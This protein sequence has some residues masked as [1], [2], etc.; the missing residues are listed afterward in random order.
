MYS[1]LYTFLEIFF[2]R[3]SCGCISRTK[4]TRLRFPGNL[5]KCTVLVH[6]IKAKV[7]FRVHFTETYTDP[8]G[9]GDFGD[10]VTT[11]FPQVYPNETLSLVFQKDI[12]LVSQYISYI[13]N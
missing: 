3:E 9:R 5:E 11:G 2:G 12:L 6:L 4:F 1:K 8:S 7:G 13:L 10:D